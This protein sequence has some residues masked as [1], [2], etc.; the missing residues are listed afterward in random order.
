MRTWPVMMYGCESWTIKKNDEDRIKAFE[1]KCIRKILRVS[2][3]EKKT[4]EWVLETAGVERSLLEDIKRRKMSYFGHLMRKHGDCLEKEIM[5]GTVPGTRTRGRPRKKWMDNM[6]EWRGADESHIR[7][8][9]M[10]KNCLQCDQSSRRGR[11]KTR[12]D[13]QFIVGANIYVQSC[14]NSTYDFSCLLKDKFTPSY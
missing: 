3:T 13:T 4:N 10:E 11:L 2:W 1:I 7:Q 8:E 14:L 12:Q 9:R 5:Q 6:S